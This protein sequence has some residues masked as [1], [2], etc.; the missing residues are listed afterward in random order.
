[1][2][3]IY[4]I[5]NL[6]NGKQYVGQTIR[7]IEERFKDHSRQA[8]SS[9]NEDRPICRAIRKYGIENFKIEELEQV[10]DDLLNEKE[11]YWIQELQTYG[12]SGYNATKGGDGHYIYD[13]D[14]FIRL[15]NM[16][17]SCNAIAKKLG[18]NRPTVTRILKANGIQ[19]RSNKRSVNQYDLAGNYIQ[20]FETIKKAAEWIIEFMFPNDS[21]KS[22]AAAI[23]NCCKGNYK[24]ARNYKWSYAD[25]EPIFTKDV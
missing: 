10:E 18:C 20:T 7:T 6:I 8:Y 22:I 5:T 16:G 24:T 14:D 2:G 11:I 25:I 1:M 21:C 3:Y 4:C 23:T 13:I 9:E 17:Y 12:K 15:Y 19:L